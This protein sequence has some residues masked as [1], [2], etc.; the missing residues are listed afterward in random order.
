LSN[1][2]VKTAINI[3]NLIGGLRSI[4]AQS[5]LTV[6]HYEQVI[7]RMERQSL[8]DY[9]NA[10][11]YVASKHAVLGL[12]HALCSEMPAHSS[13]GMI[14]PGFVATE[15]IPEAMRDLGMPVDAF[16]AITLPTL[17]A[18]GGAM[19]CPMVAPRRARIDEL[20]HPLRDA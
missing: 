18:G 12:T 5:T 17:L 10:A 9:H 7:R 8:S 13:L 11:A 1:T 2:Q 6:N 3:G 19:R 20:Y 4:A 15:L 14:A 16:A